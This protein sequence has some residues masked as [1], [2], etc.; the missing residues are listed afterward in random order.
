MTFRHISLKCLS[1]PE[2]LRVQSHQE[3]Q[4]IILR[5][6][7]CNNFVSEG[8]PDRLRGHQ[9]EKR[10]AGE[11]RNWHESTHESAH[12][13]ARERSLSLFQPFKD[14]PQKFPRKCPLELSDFTFSVFTC[15]VP[16]PISHR[17]VPWTK[18]VVKSA[19]RIQVKLS[20]DVSRVFHP[21]KVEYNAWS[22]RGRSRAP[23]KGGFLN[24]LWWAS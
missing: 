8:V 12:E 6:L 11:T 2:I 4:R 1:F 14:S 22:G 13:V 7:F 16:W 9:S 17:N 10:R 5:E 15:S 18:V 23:G 21:G 24:D 19:T 3:L 20:S